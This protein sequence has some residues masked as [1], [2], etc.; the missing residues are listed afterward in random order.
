MAA[1][2]PLT[3]REP[4]S[5]GLRGED[6]GYG[7]ERFVP[8]YVRGAVSDYSGDI[9]PR[10]AERPEDPM[11]EAYR[12]GSAEGPGSEADYL[13][14]SWPPPGYSDGPD[15]RL[16]GPVPPHSPGRH[17]KYAGELPLAADRRD[18]DPAGDFD[19][20]PEDYPAWPDR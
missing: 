4:D 2:L 12:D 14:P 7:R 18:P 13:R 17:G 3:T 1:I 15:Y 10:P 8:P 5:G 16:A 9:P 6:D 19:L 11:P 20:R